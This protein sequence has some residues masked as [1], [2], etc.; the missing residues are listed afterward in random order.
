[1]SH[2]VQVEA[3]TLQVCVLCAYVVFIQR[4]QGQSPGGN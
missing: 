2:S 1:M 3:S 4:K